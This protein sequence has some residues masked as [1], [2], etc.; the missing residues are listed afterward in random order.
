ML[1]IVTIN[2]T[3]VVDS[4]LIAEELGIAHE[5][6][7][8]T[9]KRYETKIE[10]RFGCIRF[11]IGVPDKPTG[12]PPK[13]AYLSE[14]QATALMTFSKNTDQV[15]ECKL[16]LVAAFSKAKQVIKD[17]IPQ[18]SDRIRELEL[19]NA[20][21]DK[22]LQLRQLDNSMLLMHGKQTVLALRGYDQAIV[23]VERKV[24]EVIDNRSGDKRKGM[25]TA[26]LNDYLKQKT[27][28]CFKNGAQLKRYLEK[29]A[30]ELIDIVQRPINQDWVCSEN[31]NRA[32]QILE[33]LPR[34]MLLGE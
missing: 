6:F 2:E 15:V 25:T 19:E 22:Q 18:Q 20:F 3:L 12:N 9:I 34:Q 31:I 23:E 29:I 11:E 30:P 28:Q 7:F 33:N 27:G 17:V 8:R 24:T 26:Q 1:D 13:Y 4:R 32:M 21:L 14:D 10:Q 5:S 16:N